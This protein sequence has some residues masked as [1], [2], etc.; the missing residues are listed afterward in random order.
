MNLVKFEQQTMSS[1][2]IAEL[3][4]SRHDVVKKS[5]DRLVEKGIISKPPL[6]DGIKSA[7]GIVE[8]NYAIEKRDSYV[9]VAQL[10][11]LFTAKLVDRWQELESSI[12]NQL[13]DFNNPAIAARAWADEVEAKQIALAKIES[14]KPKVDFAIAVRN[15]DGSC[16]IGEFSAL[17]GIGRN[18]FFKMFREDKILMVNNRPYQEFKDRNLFVEIENIPYTDSKGKS[19]P[20]FQT[21]VTGKGQVW[22]EKKYRN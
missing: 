10:S 18:T 5:I 12:K 4:E 17:L 3:V 20:T 15:L 7:N 1:R 11:P 19:H 16:E 22:L 9:M 6:V 21:R 13:P 14:D 8:K 2:E